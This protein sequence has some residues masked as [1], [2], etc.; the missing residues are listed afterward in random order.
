MRLNFISFLIFLLISNT[1]IAQENFPS[2]KLKSVSGKTVDFAELAASSKDTMVVLSFW[3][4]WC[5]PCITELENINDEFEEKQAIRPF[6]F[7]G[8]SIDDS[9]TSQRVKP[10]IAGKGWKFDVLMDNNS[11]LKR[12]LNVTDVPHVIIL[13][14]NKIAYSHTGYIIGEEDN[15]FETIKNL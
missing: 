10:F 1:L 7:V 6:K 2:L 12:L 15:L 5:I 14:D 3:A 8:I 4:T 13:K 9:K 11:E